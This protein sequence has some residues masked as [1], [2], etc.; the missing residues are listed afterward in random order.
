MAIKAVEE[1][2]LD[3]CGDEDPEDE[4]NGGDVVGEEVKGHAGQQGRRQVADQ[5]YGPHIGVG[6]RQPDGVVFTQTHDPVLLN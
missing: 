4:D 5:V 3:G 6:H 2:E 1:K